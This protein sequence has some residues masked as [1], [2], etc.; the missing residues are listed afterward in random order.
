MWD[1]DPHT[2]R[3]GSQPAPAAGWRQR[4]VQSRNEVTAWD[5]ERFV[6]FFK[7]FNLIEILQFFQINAQSYQVKH[8]CCR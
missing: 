3:L 7:K 2:L 1:L 6:N 8:L 4:P 5:A